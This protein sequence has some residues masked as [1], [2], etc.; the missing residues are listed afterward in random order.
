MLFLPS[1][2]LD[3][4]GSMSPTITTTQVQA[5]KRRRGVSKLIIPSAKCHC[6][7]MDPIVFP[8]PVTSIPLFLVAH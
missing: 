5:R 7:L 4:H 3:S 2:Q 8:P 1:S 6:S